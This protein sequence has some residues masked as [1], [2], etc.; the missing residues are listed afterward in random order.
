MRRY[1][2]HLF[3]DEEVRDSEGTELPN[4][5]TALHMAAKMAREMAAESVKSGR[6]TLQHRIEV[7]S[8]GGVIGVVHFGDVVKVRD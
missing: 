2:F 4:D 8:S 6:L 5:A 1:Y 7:A 3:N